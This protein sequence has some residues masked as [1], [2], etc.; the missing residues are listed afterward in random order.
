MPSLRR[1]L[2]AV[3]TALC[4]LSL[5][6]LLAACDGEPDAPGALVMDQHEYERWEIALVEMRIEK[7]DAYAAEATSP[8][9]AARIAEFEGLNYY[10]PA[11]GL[12]FEVPFTAAAGTDTVRLTKRKGQVVPYVKRGTVAF[13][14]DDKVHRLT[15]FGPATPGG[16]DYLWLP[17]YDATSRTETYPGGRYL[18]VTVDAGGLVDLDFN[19]AYNPLCDYNAERYNCT[20]PPREN[21]LPF[22]V[23]AGEKRFSVDH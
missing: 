12:R 16:Q 10:L 9:P 7:N 22:A 17:F 1:L 18:D 20:L 3:V 21:T 19:Y 15:V 5:L 6:A 11:P 4:L 23:E 13:R 14:H 2:P 8:L